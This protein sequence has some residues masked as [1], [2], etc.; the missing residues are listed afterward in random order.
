MYKII[1]LYDTYEFQSTP[2]ARGATNTIF[3]AGCIKQFQSTPPARGATLWD[4]QGDS[5]HHISIHAPRERGDLDFSSNWSGSWLFQSTPPARGATS[6]GASR[7]RGRRN[8]NPRPPREGRL[9][10][11][12]ANRVW[13][14]ISIHAPRERG[15]CSGWPV[16]RKRSDFN[17]RPPREGRPGADGRHAYHYDFNP[18]PPREGRPQ[19]SHHST[20]CI[21]F[22]STPPARGATGVLFFRFP[23]PHI[24][25]HAPRERGDRAGNMRRSR[26]SYFNPR[27]P[28]E[29][30]LI[31]TV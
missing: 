11:R 26:R 16:C 21:Q 29:G 24:S 12:R 22:Q 28:R 25:I 1:Q 17:P 27:P 19:N 6:T 5:S 14:H 9:P 18:R 20:S 23:R 3:K 31:L 7:R 10:L 2:P 4:K 30:R 8:F 13:Q 15:D